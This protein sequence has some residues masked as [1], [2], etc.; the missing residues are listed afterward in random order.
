MAKGAG[1]APFDPIEPKMVV[2]WMLAAA[3]NRNLYGWRLERFL[4]DHVV[5]RAR[6]CFPYVAALV[7]ELGT[8]KAAK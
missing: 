6:A 5:L 1:M 4:N 2:A 3:T 8:T 7:A